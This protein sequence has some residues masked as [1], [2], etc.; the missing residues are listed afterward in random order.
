MILHLN[1]VILLNS[2]GN[3]SLK[4]NILFKKKKVH[5]FLMS[6]KLGRHNLLNPV[7]KIWVISETKER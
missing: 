2:H 4:G 1:P 7:I 5:A 3:L 6:V